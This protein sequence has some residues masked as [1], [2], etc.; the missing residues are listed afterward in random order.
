MNKYD[1]DTFEII[2]NDWLSDH[3]EE[4]EDLEITGIRQGDA[5]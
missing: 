2:V 4:M 1:K 5:G 3:A